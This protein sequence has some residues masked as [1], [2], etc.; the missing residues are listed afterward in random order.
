M[1]IVSFA[2]KY[3]SFNEKN[4]WHHIL[5][6]RLLTSGYIQDKTGVITLNKQDKKNRSILVLAPRFH[7]KS[8][9]VSFIYP[10]YLICKNPN[11]RIL[12]VSANEEIASSFVRQVL[13]QLENNEALL[14]DFPGLI[15]QR[16][17]KWGEKAFIVKRDTIEKDPTFAAAGIMGKIISKRADVI[18]LDDVIDMELSRTK[19]QREKVK[20]WYNNVL[21]PIL[22]QKN[23]QLL[24]VGTSWHKGDLYDSLYEEGYFDVKLKLKA[25]ISYSK[26]SH[27]RDNIFGKITPKFP[28][29]RYPLYFDVKGKFSW[30]VIREL[31]EYNFLTS[32]KEGVL[33]KDKWDLNTLEE[34]RKKIGE[35]AFHRQYLNE[36]VSSTD[37][38]FSKKSIDKAVFFG[39]NYY[40][41]SS[42]EAGVSYKHFPSNLILAMGVDFA[43][44]FSKTSDYS[45]IAI[46]GLGE[47]QRRYLVYLERFKKP[48]DEIKQHIIDLYYLYHPQKVIVESN[49]FQDILRKELGEEIDVEGIKTTS[50][51]KFDES[52]GLTH[53]QMLFDQEK[54]VLPGNLKILPSFY[55]ELLQV[56]V[57]ERSHTPDTVMASWFALRFLKNYSELLSTSSSFLTAEAIS[58]QATKISNPSK[59]VIVPQVNIIKTSYNSFFSF[60]GKKEEIQNK[61]FIFSTYKEGRCVAYFFR[62][63]DGEMMGKIEGNITPTFFAQW[64][65]QRE[66]FFKESPVSVYMDFEGAILLASLKASGYSNLYVSYPNDEGLPEFSTFV[67]KSP[68]LVSASFDNLKMKLLPVRSK[69]KIKDRQLLLELTKI[70][71]ITGEKINY[72]SNSFPQ[73]AL[74]FALGNYLWEFNFKDMAKK[75]KNEGI[76]KNK[77]YRIFK[78]CH[79][80][81]FNYT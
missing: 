26:T 34:Q 75:D 55:E 68:Y 39:K 30:G 27:N 35:V 80:T 23:G 53:M 73:R 42:Y 37:T 67:P 77:N 15:P 21:Y 43:A 7:S 16:H 24:V 66:K 51:N 52:A 40:A 63:E 44:T 1:D 50:L 32:I 58:R 45:A 47:D 2:N 70:V 17:R 22:D 19:S 46:W 61:Y 14:K 12:I 36:P 9:I 3:F 60:W 48:I 13:F 78:K 10:L 49:V 54:I 41:P 69:F 57:D 18:I 56:R 74:T 25:L 6:Y 31:K 29:R 76:E 28:A 59:Y 81:V 38:F 5:F 8:T 20:E 79:Y 11:I 62:M 65:T 33:W 4:N 72:T 64:L 71:S